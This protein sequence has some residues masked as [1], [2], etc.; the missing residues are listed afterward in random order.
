MFASDRA[1]HH[2][3]SRND[4]IPTPSQPINSCSMLFAVIM[5]SI[6]MRKVSKCLIN[7]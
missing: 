2:P 1:Y 3:M 7:L 5:I 6:A 4:I